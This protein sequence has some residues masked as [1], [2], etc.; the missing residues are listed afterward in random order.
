MSSILKALKKVQEHKG[1]SGE[2]APLERQLLGGQVEPPQ[3]QRKT[4]PVLIV[5][6][7]LVIAGIGGGIYFASGPGETPSK[8]QLASQEMVGEPVAS[9]PVVPQVTAPTV[10]PAATAQAA[11]TPI[12]VAEE[13]ALDPSTA[14]ETLQSTPPE[15]AVTSQP[16]EPP[17]VITSRPT[18]APK[19]V[20]PAAS[21]V[22]PAQVAV[23]PPTVQNRS[24]SPAPQ[25]TPQ[26]PVRTV[27]APPQP[28][29]SPRAVPVKPAPALPR[30]QAVSPV[31]ST[32]IPA[33]APVPV[34]VT[35]PRLMVSG[36]VYQDDPTHHYALV[37]DRTVKEGQTVS[38]AVVEKIFKDHVLF[39]YQSQPF[40]IFMGHDTPLD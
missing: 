30:N 16:I 39:R 13:A 17:P 12:S 21:T 37:N 10:A 32:P 38:G 9:P 4:V 25:V 5:L 28:P 26:Q 14:A 2:S 3:R 22:Q 19:V 15:P 34:K 23:P 31:P 36:I 8:P 33:V 27:A 40:E 6:F 29:A 35:P 1:G 7:V 20:E 24:S 11:G 18:P